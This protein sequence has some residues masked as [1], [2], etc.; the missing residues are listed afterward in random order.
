MVLVYVCLCFL[1]FGRGVAESARSGSK[2][3]VDGGRQAA[4]AR[5]RGVRGGAGVGAE[6]VQ[7]GLTGAGVGAKAVQQQAGPCDRSARE[8]AL[9][10]GRARAYGRPLLR[11][12]LP[13]EGMHV[14]RASED[15]SLNL[16]SSSSFTSWASPERYAQVQMMDGLTFFQV[17]DRLT[18]LSSAGWLDFSI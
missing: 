15:V 8:D 12:G 6:V 4:P 1:F 10:A 9:L 11:L 13:L 7:C 16:S 5:E 18:F 3:V 17:R 14:G 2:G